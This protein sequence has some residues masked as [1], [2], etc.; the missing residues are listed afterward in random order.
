MA[1][2]Q[3]TEKGMDRSSALLVSAAS[4]WLFLECA[5]LQDALRPQVAAPPARLFS[6]PLHR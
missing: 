6:S 2:N 1:K 4:Q 5:R 3:D